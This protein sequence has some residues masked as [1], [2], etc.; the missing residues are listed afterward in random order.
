MT[1]TRPAAA[2]SLA[3][4]AVLGALLGLVGAF[5]VPLR[6]AG[7]PVPVSAVLAALGN[8]GLGLAG[9]RAAGDRLGVL[10]P[11]AG[12][13]GVVT[14]ASMRGPGGDVVLPGSLGSYAFLLGGTAASAAAFAFAGSRSAATPRSRAGR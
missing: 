8:F 4:L 14:L 3:L 10:A 9:A 5:L 2:A 7:V 11:A 1:R 6:V 12:W 13:F